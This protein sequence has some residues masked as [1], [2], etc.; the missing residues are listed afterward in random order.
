MVTYIFA[1]FPGTGKKFFI[2]NN[3]DKSILNLSTTDFTHIIDG[4][5]DPRYPKN[6]VDQIMEN[7]GK[8]K[9]IFISTDETVLNY[10]NKKGVDF[11]I[12]YP[13]VYLKN[14]YLARFIESGKDQQ[15]ISH[16]EEN[17]NSI[18]E[19]FEDFDMVDQIKLH[20]NEF[21]SDLIS[22]KLPENRDIE[23]LSSYDDMEM[24]DY[25]L[26]QNYSSVD[27][28]GSNMYVSDPELAMFIG[29]IFMDQALGCRYIPWIKEGFVEDAEIEDHVE[30]F[31]FIDILGHWKYKPTYKEILA[32]Y[33]KKNN[34]IFLLK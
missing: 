4:I 12:V 25:F 21:I 13:S 29:Y 14:E 17:W 24:G 10:L 18:I 7:L 30:W 32:A 26:F 11:I 5:K 8:Y 16:M 33:R 22:F 9:V 27:N 1:T 19:S 31:D 34:T 23:P 28:G 6:Y 3:K 20:T 15:Y 2:E